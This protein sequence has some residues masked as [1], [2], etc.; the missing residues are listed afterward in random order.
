VSAKSEPGTA[1]A[2]A[3]PAQRRYRRRTVRIAVR[4]ALHA[5]TR[6]A[7]ATTL[8]AG[9]LFVQTDRPLPRGTRLAVRFRLPGASE[10][11]D[12]AARVVFAQ[13]P[14]GG[15]SAG[16]GLEFTDTQAVAR[17]AHALE[18]LSD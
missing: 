10:E 18:A 9:G 3:P 2:N 15:G 6:A 4:F 17:I 7:T 5:E 13:P 12:L 16:M 14:G 8:G 11:F 1:A